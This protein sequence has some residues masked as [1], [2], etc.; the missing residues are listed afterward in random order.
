[1]APGAAKVRIR[2]NLK[3]W[4]LSVSATPSE[5]RRWR[6]YEQYYL[7]SDIGVTN[8]PVQQARI[9][10]CV[11]Q[12]LEQHLY[13]LISDNT[14]VFTQEPNEDE[15]VSC[16]DIIVD[17]I[18]ER[19]PLDA[20]WIELFK[21][22]Q[23]RGEL[24]VQYSKQDAGRSRRVRPKQHHPARDHG[25]GIHHPLLLAAIPQRAMQARS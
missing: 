18:A 1:M 11:D 5:F 4:E 21:L 3:Q 6:K 19:H 16:M 24:M 13:N 17:W 10:G 7:G 25:H 2:H 14:P 23:E 15:E 20:R 9:S 8:L 12:E 22:P